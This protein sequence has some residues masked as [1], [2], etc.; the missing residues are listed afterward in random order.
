MFDGPNDSQDES[1]VENA[2]ELLVDKI[3][4][5]KVLRASTNEE[6]DQLLVQLGG[7]GKPE[8]DTIAQLSEVRPLQHPER[9]EEAHRMVVRSLE[10]L[11][12]N[13]PRQAKVPNVGPLKPIASWLVEQATGFIVR[14]HLNKIMNRICGLYERR[15]ANSAWHTPEHHMLRRARIDMIRV[16]DGMRAKSLGLP[17][18][19]VGGA[20][21]TS[22]ASALQSVVS[23]AFSHK[24]GVIALGVA[25]VGVLL[26]LSWAALFSAGVARRRIRLATD[27][28]VAALWE[29]IGAAGDP[30]RDESYNFAAYAIVLLVLA[31]ILIPLAIGLAIFR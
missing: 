10:V 26:G 31:W 13:G 27:Q 28:P 23:L 24:V 6:R 2:T 4:A 30:P 5:L 3:D 20:L 14:S 1:V 22:I 21:L 9:F 11:D 18:F 12:R 15:E 7:R 8:Q 17:S 29:T 25:A 16:R 19:I